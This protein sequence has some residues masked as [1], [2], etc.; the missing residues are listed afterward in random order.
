[1]II[2]TPY[3]FCLTPN[4]KCDTQWPSTW[5][6]VCTT[7]SLILLCKRIRSR[8][9]QPDNRQLPLTWNPVHLNIKVGTTSGYKYPGKKSNIFGRC[10]IKEVLLSATSCT[11]H[12]SYWQLW[13]EDFKRKISVKLRNALRTQRRKGHYCQQKCLQESS[14]FTWTFSCQSQNHQFLAPTAKTNREETKLMDEF[15]IRFLWV[16][17]GRV[18][19]GIRI[20]PSR[21]LISWT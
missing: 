4:W 21:D 19:S 7:A 2:I 16:C 11:C 3:Y 13:W 12:E 17:D 6:T 9:C 10:R 18:V 20:A 1:M 8:L 14:V 15:K 5:H